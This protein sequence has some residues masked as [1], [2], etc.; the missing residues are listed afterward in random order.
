MIYNNINKK[1]I[2][3]VKNK[4]KK[5]KK[6]KKKFLVYNG[7]WKL[8]NTMYIYCIKTYLLYN[9]FQYINFIS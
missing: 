2:K 9:I 1:N 8:E 3:R 5:K 7:K 4:K 6:K